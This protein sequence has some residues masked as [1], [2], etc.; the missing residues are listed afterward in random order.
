MATWI[1]ASGDER[2]LVRACQAGEEAAMRS[3]YEHFFSPVFRYVLA[4]VGHR[5][6]A[7]D[8]TAEVFAR[9]LQGLGSWRDDSRPVAAWLFR[10]AHNQVADHF[11]RKG[12]RPAGVPLD[13]QRIDDAGRYDPLE[14]KAILLDLARA[15]GDLPAPQREA[16]LLRAVAG[17]T[18]REAAGV[19]RIPEGTLRSHLHFG[20][21]ALRAAM[22]T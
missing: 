19:M 14:G 3:F 2:E 6:D 15:I 9:A 18:T 11:R 20:L 22:E 8:I 4:T 16:V 12:R 7:E 17:L 21:K 1:G 5:Q 10:I 13:A